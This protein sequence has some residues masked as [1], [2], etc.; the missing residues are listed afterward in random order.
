MDNNLPPSCTESLPDSSSSK[1][2]KSYIQI[3][4]NGKK[5]FKCAVL[6]CGK[7]F[8]FKS[9][10]ER[11]GTSHMEDK[12][13]ACPD[14]TCNRTFKREEALKSHMESHKESLDYV[15]PISGCDQKFNKR[16]IMQ[17]H[18][19]KHHTSK[20]FV[21]NT[22]GCQ[23]VFETFK[24][25]RKHQREGC[26]SEQEKLLSARDEQTEVTSIWDASSPSL[27][28]CVCIYDFENSTPYFELEENKIK[29]E[30]NLEPE[31]EPEPE[32]QPQPK[33]LLHTEEQTSDVEDTSKILQELISE[34]Q[35]AALAKGQNQDLKV[36]GVLQSMLG[37]LKQENQELKEKLADILSQCGKNS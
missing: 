7:I 15:C 16:S 8:R 4:N 19:N 35:S 27:C 13:F 24:L 32:P 36:E 23:R 20:D 26:A 3:T 22:K 33:K 6:G 30:P 5:A 29:C 9:D 17:Y 11:H 28:L 37:H 31:P 14:P 2:K 10:M 18:I 12:P 34:A 21:C 25:L 1:Q